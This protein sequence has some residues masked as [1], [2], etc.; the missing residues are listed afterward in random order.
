MSVRAAAESSS[1]V[2]PHG[3]A[4]GSTT[5]SRAAASRCESAGGTA[6]PGTGRCVPPALRR[7][8]PESHP[9]SLGLSFDH[10]AFAQYDL[11]LYGQLGRGQL[12][13]TLGN[14]LGH[15]FQ[16]EHDAAGL[17]HCNPQFRIAFA[18]AH[19][20]LGG[21]LGHWLV[22]ENPDPDLAAAF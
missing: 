19:A 5:D 17:D 2:R 16:L 3:A 6:P 12:E 9:R 20:G 1:S 21:L 4:Y 10:C 13:G 15:A 18:F 11:A 14:F 7:S 8:V 22:R